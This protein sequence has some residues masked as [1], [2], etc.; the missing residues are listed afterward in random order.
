MNFSSFRLVL[1]IS[2]LCGV[3]GFAQDAPPKKTGPER[4]EADI[5]KFE[6]QEKTN[7]APKGALLFLGSSSIRMWKLEVSFPNRKTINRGFG[8]STLADSIHYFDRL[9]T[10]HAPKA[11]IVYAGDNDIKSGLTADQVV[12]DFKKLAALA[13][14]KL[15]GTPLIFIAIKP[16]TSR[17]SLWPTMQTANEKIASWCA[18]NEGFFY[19]DIAAP[20][21]ADVEAGQPP[22][23]TLFLKD[24]LHMTP[25]G[26]AIWKK[27]IDTLLKEV[28]SKKA[29]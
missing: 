3:S 2:L 21:L 27:V 5:A 7:P 17:W 15:P 16:S 24:G 13:G 11:I 26:Y 18:E 6:A 8:G 9:V 25:E 14:E 10:P 1:L 4:W 12:A 20:M 19:A 28:L 23:D 29:E 22:K